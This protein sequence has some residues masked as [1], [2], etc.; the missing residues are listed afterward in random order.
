MAI[1]LIE[2]MPRSFRICA[3]RPISSHSLS[4]ACASSWP[5]RSW[6]AILRPSVDGADADR[7]FAEIDDDAAALLGDALHDR[8]RAASA[9]RTRRR[10]RFPDAGGP[11]CRCRRGC[12]RRP[13]RGAASDPRAANRCAPWP[14]RSGVSMSKVATQL[15]QRFL[16]L[17]IGDE[18]GDR[19]LLQAVLL[20]EGRDLRAARDGAV[21]IDEF[22][23]H[24]DRRQAGEPAE[25]DGGFRMA[26]AHQHAA[27]AG[28]QREDV[29]GTDEIGGPDIRIGKIAHRQRA[30][31][32][33]NAGRRAVL[34]I[35]RDGEGGR[36]RRI[37]FGH[38]GVEVQALG[39]F[40]SASACRRCPRCGGR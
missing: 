8:D 4:R 36:V 29:A 24:A 2:V 40:A 32:G 34:E 14:C 28:D 9:C 35:D 27:F 37:V 17:A 3:P 33:G 5:S 10:R 12:R 20:G 31:V 19:D 23:D 30:V 21:V 15:D 39:L 6:L 38:H 13:R 16:A 1:S 7:A 26:G 25:I 22:A 18:V 11:E